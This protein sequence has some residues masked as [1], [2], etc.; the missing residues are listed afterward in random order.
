MSKLANI[1]AKVK[2]EG[3]DKINNFTGNRTSSDK[4]VYPFWDTKVG[5]DVV[6]R[7]LPDADQNNPFPYIERSFIDLPFSGIVGKPDASDVKVRVP[8]MDMYKE[9]DPIITETRAW[10]NDEELKDLAKVY[11]KKRSYL[12]QGLVI[13]DGLRE[14]SP[15]EDPIRRFIIGPQLHKIIKIA[16]NNPDF[17]TNVTDYYDGT[18]FRIVKTKLGTQADYTT[19]TWARRTRPLSDEHLA[20]IEKYGL[21]DLKTY[22]PKKPTPEEQAI[23]MEMF[24]ASVNGEEYD[25]ARWGEFYKPFGMEDDSTPAQP[26]TYS[27]PTAVPTV[28]S[29]A[30]AEDDNEDDLPYHPSPAATA[31]TT[32]G[33]TKP[34][35]ADILNII[36][37]RGNKA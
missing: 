11:W 3:L 1:R 16:D 7:F 25:P 24:E 8:C 31:V 21:L 30:T 13:E 10:W 18:D 14:E 15:P 34:A 36:R 32:D 19:S 35:A 9:P 26:S 20:A 29:S 37:N 2:S 28:S 12:F 27:R 33:D 5:T 6:L 4:A 17:E 22:L 23:I